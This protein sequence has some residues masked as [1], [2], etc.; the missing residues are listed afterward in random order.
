MRNA[1]AHKGFR[2]LFAALATSML[3][4][5][6]MLIVL[7]M[8]VK[9]LTGSNAMAGLTFLCLVSPS[10]VAP[11]FGMFVDRVRRRPL[12]IWGNVAS[13]LVVLPLLLVRDA[14]QVWLVWVVAFLYG[15]SF[16]VMPAGVNGMLKE[17]L[18]EDRLVDA[19]SALTTTK[20]GFRLIGPLAGAALFAA[21]GGGAVAA[22]DALSFLVAALVVAR[23]RVREDAP[24]RAEQHWW[25]EMT[26]GVRH[27]WHEPVL[28]HTLAALGLTITVLGFAES[29][30]FAVT[31]A[32]GKPVEFVGVVLTVQGVG[33][34]V[35]GLTAPRVVRRVTE[36]GALALA[37]LALAG[38]QVG[39]ALA[40]ALW[41]VLASVVLLGW[42]IPVLLIG[43][44]TLMQRLTPGRLMGRVSAATDVVLGT[45]QTV[46]IALGAALVSLVSYRAIFLTMAVVTVAAVGYL[47]ITLRDRLF[48]A[49]AA[50]AEA[51]VQA[52]A[53]TATPTPTVVPAGVGVEV[54]TSVLE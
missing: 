9:S 11:L 28:R 40:P 27:V 52:G 13:A 22:L 26:E 50:D 6:L 8:W 3:G 47:A 53:G 31:D 2:P 48:R 34:L 37:L 18:P 24:A 10:L 19:N 23:V 51:P 32:F 54:T 14:G 16:V 43:F 5:S 38:G 45:P 21:V 15:I 44:T 17:M 30:V 41:A 12:L 42:S 25:H 4:D 33:A 36:P 35:G 7:S 1:F 29:A 49:V 39:I 20:E 46:G